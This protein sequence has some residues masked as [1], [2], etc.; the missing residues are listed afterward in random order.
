MDTTPCS[1]PPPSHP[2][3]VA[4][5]FSFAILTFPPVLCQ[6]DAMSTAAAAT[7][8]ARAAQPDP[9]RAWARASA[10]PNAVAVLIALVV[11]LLQ[12]IRSLARAFRNHVPQPGDSLTGRF[13]GTAIIHAIGTCMRPRAM[14]SQAL[15][16]AP[17]RPREAGLTVP[18]PCLNPT[19]PAESTGA[20]RDGQLVPIA[21][22]GVSVTQFIAEVDRC[23]APAARIESPRFGNG[24]PERRRP[25]CLLAE[26]QSCDHAPPQQKSAECYCPETKPCVASGKAF[27]Q[28]ETAPVL[29][30]PVSPAREVA[31][32]ASL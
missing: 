24:P 23:Q 10:T 20:S 15:Y 27:E 18:Q 5:L 31:T 1:R 3:L 13:P 4:K 6:T 28:T 19:N 25:D 12:Q 16:Q 7:V 26:E 2:P 22:F 8:S 9:T 21:R 14:R 32:A 17:A 11:A 29:H 30:W